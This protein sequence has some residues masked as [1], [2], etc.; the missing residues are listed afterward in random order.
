MKG[1]RRTFLALKAA[2]QFP[3][4][5]AII[6]IANCPFSVVCFLTSPKALDDCRSASS[7]FRQPL[8]ATLFIEKK[9]SLYILNNT[10]C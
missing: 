5:E 7:G 2:A 3:E 8:Y 10:K 1:S 4:C 9:N 6:R